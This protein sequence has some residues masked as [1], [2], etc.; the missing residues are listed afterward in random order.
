MK[1]AFIFPLISILALAACGGGG[2]DGDGGGNTGGVASSRAELAKALFIATR[3]P[4]FE[5]M[6][7]QF[8]VQG[9]ATDA[10]NAG[11]V[12]TCGSGGTA[13]VS[14]VTENAS[15]GIIE[16]TVVMSGCLDEGGNASPD[17]QAYYQ[18]D[19]NNT[20]LYL[21]LGSG[22]AHFQTTIYGEDFSDAFTYGYLGELAFGRVESG[23]D[24]STTVLDEH[25]IRFFEQTN[26]T[27]TLSGRAVGRSEV[28]VESGG[29]ELSYHDN[30]VTV[31]SSSSC[32]STGQYTA[33]TTVPGTR[34]G[35]LG[36]F[37]NE[38]WAIGAPNGGGTVDFAP[39]GD[40]TLDWGNGSQTMSW[41][42][43]LSLVVQA[44]Q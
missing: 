43:V 8:D 6:D 5:E 29:R 21:L 35:A 7:F 19:Q 25:D 20:E 30:T 32:F 42:G 18:L 12:A 4:S 15:G 3:Q 22:D 1:K 28:V 41:E 2:G 34:S 26:G 37:S 24:G 13:R 40:L 23:S 31:D 38:Q 33:S 11:G 17:G 16:A 10:H 27:T 39:N 9:F 36:G 14:G 44:C